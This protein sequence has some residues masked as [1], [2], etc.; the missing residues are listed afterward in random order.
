MKRAD[1]D[2][3]VD[4]DNEINESE[5]CPHGVLPCEPCTACIVDIVLSD[6]D[7]KDQTTTKKER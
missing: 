7:Q 4:P 6:L 3:D 1:L 5:E 2:R